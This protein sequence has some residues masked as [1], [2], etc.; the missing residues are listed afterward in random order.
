MHIKKSSIYK[1]NISDKLNTESQ[2]IEN[3]WH[4]VTFI[5]RKDSKSMN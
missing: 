1:E 5:V 4:G 3:E 2:F